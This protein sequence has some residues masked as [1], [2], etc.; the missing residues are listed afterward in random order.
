METNEVYEF[1]PFRTDALRKTLTRNGQ[2]VPLPPKAFDVLCALLQKAGKTVIK[3]ELMK[4]V[5]PDTFVEEGNL[6][7]MVSVLRKA[8]GESEGAQSLIV[9]VPRQGYR[10]VGDLTGIANGPGPSGAMAGR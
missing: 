7:Q 2:P 3:D 9:T 6:A 1:G 5:W 8:L 4:L 10:F